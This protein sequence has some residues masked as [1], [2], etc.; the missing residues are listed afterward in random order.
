MKLY[1]ARK[2][3]K[4][5]RS[6]EHVKSIRNGNALNTDGSKMLGSGKLACISGSSQ[7]AIHENISQTVGLDN[8]DGWCASD[9]DTVRQVCE[10][11]EEN[12]IVSNRVAEFY[13]CDCLDLAMVNCCSETDE[14][15]YLNNGFVMK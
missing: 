14:F 13:D 3:N 8:M 15:A 1:K 2:L 4:K 11:T 7:N 6:R 9:R 12:D 10:S 5:Q